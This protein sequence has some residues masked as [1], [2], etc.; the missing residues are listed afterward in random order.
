MERLENSLSLEQQFKQR[1]FAERV[2]QL[3]RV[4]AQELLVQMH[5]H[6]LCKDNMYQKLFLSPEK[7]IVDDLLGDRQPGG[8]SSLLKRKRD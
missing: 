5:E 6:M 1:V 7:K 4:E 2:Q 8:E 3:S